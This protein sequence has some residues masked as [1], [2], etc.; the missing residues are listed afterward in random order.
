LWKDWVDDQLT[1]YYACNN[2][3][4]DSMVTL[5]AQ[6]YTMNQRTEEFILL[7]KILLGYICYTGGIS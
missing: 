6:P 1:T 7:K 4:N 2:K 5:N 3:A